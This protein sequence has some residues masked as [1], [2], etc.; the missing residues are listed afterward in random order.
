ME[1][2]YTKNLNY[3]L[4]KWKSGSTLYLISIRNV[5]SWKKIQMEELGTGSNFPLITHM[6]SGYLPKILKRLFI[7][8]LWHTSP[9]SYC[10]KLFNPPPNISAICSW[11]KG[12]ENGSLPAHTLPNSPFRFSEYYSSSRTAEELIF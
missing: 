6:T 12:R 5:V 9:N 4:F 11:R 1:V 7:A 8:L 3:F 10:V 2:I